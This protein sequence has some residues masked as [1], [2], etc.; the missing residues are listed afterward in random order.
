MSFEIQ[1]ATIE[2]AP[3]LAVVQREAFAEDAIV[4]YLFK[5][6]PG[7]VSV[8]HD[9]KWMSSFFKE[10]EIQTVRVSKV[11]DMSSRYDQLPILLS[12]SFLLD[13]RYTRIALIVRSIR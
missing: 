13:L 5:D 2:D 7:D 9:V 12:T 4:G 10:S 1:P 8:E 6:V 11:V 3:V